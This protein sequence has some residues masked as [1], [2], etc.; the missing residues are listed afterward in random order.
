LDG[1]LRVLEQTANERRDLGSASAFSFAVSQ[2]QQRIE[3]EH[4]NYIED[5]QSHFRLFSFSR[6]I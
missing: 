3:Q 1:I 5:A 4:V 6:E 2:M